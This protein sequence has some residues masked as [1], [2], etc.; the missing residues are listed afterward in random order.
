MMKWTVIVYAVKSALRTTLASLLLKNQ[1]PKTKQKPWQLI[2]RLA[3][4]NLR[5]IQVP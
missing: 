4:Y 1:S 2:R 3:F 5:L